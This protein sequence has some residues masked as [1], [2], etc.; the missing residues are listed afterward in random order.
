METLLKIQE[1]KK[2]QGVTQENTKSK[3]S[4]L[5][6]KKSRVINGIRFSYKYKLVLRLKNKEIKER[7]KNRKTSEWKIV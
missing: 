2:G 5:W 4:F 1:S 3:N 7:K 6:N